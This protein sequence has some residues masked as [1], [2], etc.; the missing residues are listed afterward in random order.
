VRALRRPLLQPRERS[1]R[2]SGTRSRRTCSSSRRRS[3]S[4]RPRLQPT[5][6]RPMRSRMRLSDSNA[7]ISSGRTRT[8]CKALS[9]TCATCGKRSS[10]SRHP[11]SSRLQQVGALLPCAYPCARS[12]ACLVGYCARSSCY[13]NLTA[14][15]TCAHALPRAPHVTLRGLCVRVHHPS[16]CIDGVALSL[17]H[18]VRAASHLVHAP[19]GAADFGTWVLSYLVPTLALAHR[20]VCLAG[21][22]ARSSCYKNLTVPSCCAH[23]PCTDIWPRNHAPLFG[24]LALS[25]CSAC[26]PV[27]KSVWRLY[28]CVPRPPN[29][30][31]AL[32]CS[33][34]VHRH[35]AASSTVICAHALPFLYA[36]LRHAALIR[37]KSCLAMP[38]RGRI[39]IYP[40]PRLHVVSGARSEYH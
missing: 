15:S 32:L 5:R 19:R 3:R 9:R 34:G 30:A 37:H 7:L 18:R 28:P 26:S 14:P 39:V 16:L 36:L 35:Q 6:P 24:G 25:G 29:F 33:P 12:S 38:P 20:L 13:E 40:C 27:P 4:W 11:R 21:Y 2:A 23:N 1:S 10:S 17:P 31:R 8:A 22:C